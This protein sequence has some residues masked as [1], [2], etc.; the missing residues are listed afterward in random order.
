MAAPG[1]E[2]WSALRAPVKRAAKKVIPAVDILISPFVY[3]CAL[4][5]KFVRQTGIKR[6]PRSKAMLLRAGCFPVRDHYYEPAFSNASIRELLSAERELPGIAWDSEGQRRLLASFSY[7][8]EL[9]TLPRHQSGNGGFH[10]DN[11]AFGSGDA[12]YWYN[13]IRLKKPKRIIEVGS[14]FS[15]K[16]ARLALEANEREDPEYAC[17]H[18]LIEPYEHDWLEGLGI[19]VIREKVENTE[20]QMFSSLAAGDILFIDSSHVIRPRGDVVFEYLDILPALDVGVIVHIHDIF[21]P[22]DYPAEWVVDEVRFWNE[23]YLLEA[24][25]TLNNDWKVI[26]ALNFLRHHHYQELKARCPFLTDDREPGSFYI[27]RVSRS[28]ALN[29]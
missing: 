22:K 27:E 9:A 21:L 12:E 7:N 11:G 15:T 20:I 8:H 26:G 28:V 25:L 4:L 18:I 16:I 23:Q 2:G 6:L 14:G 10:V 24:F 13:L 5:L 17:D 1:E 3:C 19:T 29:C